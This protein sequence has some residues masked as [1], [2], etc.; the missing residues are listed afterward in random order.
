M[1]SIWKT[2]KKFEITL[3]GQNLFLILFENE[4]DLEFIM[5]ER[6][7]L[8]LKHIIIFERLVEQMD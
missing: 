5:E 6:P 4:E 1:G 3:V 7:W 8:F 2:R